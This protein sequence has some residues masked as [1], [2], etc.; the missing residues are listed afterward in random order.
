MRDIGPGL[1]LGSML[2]C[3]LVEAGVLVGGALIGLRHAAFGAILP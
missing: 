3:R 1:A 2:L